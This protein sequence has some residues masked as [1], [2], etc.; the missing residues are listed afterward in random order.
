M[1]K[2]HGFSNAF[3][4]LCQRPFE[5]PYRNALSPE[6]GLGRMVERAMGFLK[7]LQRLFKGLLKG[8]GFSK[9]LQ[10]LFK[11]LLKCLAV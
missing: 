3:L 4:R 5:E 8:K 11:E 2:G 9:A 10:R 6:I 7:A 1:F